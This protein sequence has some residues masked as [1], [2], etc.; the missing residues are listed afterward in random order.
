MSLIKMMITRIL[1][2]RKVKLQKKKKKAFLY[3]QFCI[4]DQWTICS[5]N[6]DYFVLFSIDYNFYW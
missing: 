1:L 5:D 3:F 4:I 2:F 6:I